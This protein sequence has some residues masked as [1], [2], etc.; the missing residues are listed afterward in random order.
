MIFTVKL[1]KKLTP[2]DAQN[3]QGLSSNYQKSNFEKIQ[4]LP[5]N[6]QKSNFEKLQDK[7]LKCL[8]GTFMKDTRNFLVVMTNSIYLQGNISRGL[9]L[10]NH[11]KTHITV[12]TEKNIIKK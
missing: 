7:S 4:D 11:T 9:L 10:P 1:K 12:N 5:S 3:L 6:Y 8:K 2:K